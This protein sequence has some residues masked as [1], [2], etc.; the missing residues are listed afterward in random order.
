[1]QATN[2]GILYV[3]DDGVLAQVNTRVS[4]TLEARSTYMCSVIQDSFTKVLCSPMF[5][6]L[7]IVV[8]GSK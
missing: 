3:D 6:A 2:A 8:V 5:E 7:A 1:M 4:D